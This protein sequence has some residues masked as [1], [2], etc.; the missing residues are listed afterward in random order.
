MKRE[1]LYPITVAESRY[2]GI[3]SG[4]DWICVTGTRNISET[5]ATAGDTACMAFWEGA[6]HVADDTIAT[7]GPTPNNAVKQACL[8]AD[9]ESDTHMFDESEPN[10]FE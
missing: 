7:S 2:N 4:G 8:V 3:Y 10:I 5:N 9:G 1:D 6:P